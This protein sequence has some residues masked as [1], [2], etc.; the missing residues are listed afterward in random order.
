[1]EEGIFRGRKIQ[2]SQEYLSLKQSKQIQ[3]LACVGIMIHHVTQQITS[4]GSNPKGPVTVFGF[5]CVKPVAYFEALVYNLFYAFFKE[6]IVDWRV[7]F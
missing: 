7:V 4:Y 1:M 3:A 5:Y 2:F 6:V